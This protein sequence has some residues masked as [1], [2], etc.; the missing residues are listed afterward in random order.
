MSVPTPELSAWS[1]P[2]VIMG[3]AVLLGTPYLYVSLG[4]CITE[5]SGRVNL[6]QEGNLFLGALAG[7]AVSY[8][9]NSPWLGVLA[10]GCVGLVMGV[11]HALICNL[12]R[13][14]YAS[15]SASRS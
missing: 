11:L 12:P 14:N 8:Q 3:R 9:F 1:I 4:E 10:A 5:K 13:V 6:G 7:F 2:L 15:P